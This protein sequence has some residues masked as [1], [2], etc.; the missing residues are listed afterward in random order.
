LLLLSSSWLPSCLPRSKGA[1]AER[2][3]APSGDA[4]TPRT[5]SARERMRTAEELGPL[6]RRAEELRE[7]YGRRGMH[8]L[9]EP[10]FVVIGDEHPSQVKQH[11]VSTIRWAV[12]RLRKQFFAR[13]PDR[14]IDV[15]LFGSD[16]SY[17]AWAKELFDETPSTPYGYYSSQHNALVMNIGTGGGTLVHEIVHPYMATNFPACPSWF[18]EGL[19]SLF[20]QSSERDGKIVGLENWRLPALQDA[21]RRKS[22]PSTLALTRTGDQPFYDEDPGTNYAQARYLAYWL[23]EQGLLEDF[24]REFVAAADEDPTGAATLQRIV[25]YDDMGRFDVMWRKFVL[26][27]QWS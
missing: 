25:D 10:P 5:S 11:A 6:E 2:D 15:W 1:D 14:I 13:D 22:V 16:E 20:E 23:Q 17:I 26:G 3:P 24:Y 27:L 8:V 9:V 7:S 19:A 21:I 18:D 12:E 4:A